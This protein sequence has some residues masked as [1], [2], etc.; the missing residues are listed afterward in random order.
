MP[1]A[2]LPLL[3]LHSHYTLS[4]ITIFT[5]EEVKHS[6]KPH[7]SCYP[8]CAYV[9]KNNRKFLNHIMIRH[10]WSNFA[11]SKC[12][13]VAAT[14]GQQLK[15]HFF[16]CPSICETSRKPNSCGST[17]TKKGKWDKGDQCGNDGKCSQ[18]LDS[19]EWDLIGTVYHNYHCPA[20]IIIFNFPDLLPNIL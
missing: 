7:I 12:M 8:I 18:K 13:D 11:C 4:H 5:A 16:K 17:Q 9:I 19:Q 14:L 20:L 15:R 3:E 2:L 6:H 10:Y 1:L